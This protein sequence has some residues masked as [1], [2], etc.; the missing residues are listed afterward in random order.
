MEATTALFDDQYTSCMSS[1]NLLLEIW[2]KK[3]E[4]SGGSTGLAGTL[5]FVERECALEGTSGPFL[6]DK[7][8]KW[9]TW[10]IYDLLLFRSPQ[11]KFDGW[12]LGLKSC[13][14]IADTS[15]PVGCWGW[16][17]YGT[18]E[19]RESLGKLN[20]QTVSYRCLTAT[21]N[22]LDIHEDGGACTILENESIYRTYGSNYKSDYQWWWRA[23]M[24]V[25]EILLITF[26]YMD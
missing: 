23:G 18:L 10:E 8:T 19:L 24:C 14:V 2:I 12:A 1:L 22:L 15:N 13:L 6:S 16:P 3:M 9:E 5:R 25:N 7:T 20:N 4:G 11:I 21:V 17:G 26:Q